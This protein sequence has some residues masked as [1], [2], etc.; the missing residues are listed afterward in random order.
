MAIVRWC[1]ICGVTGIAHFALEHR[2]AASSRQA[3][4]RA[5]LWHRAI[6]YR[7][8]VCF[9]SC[10]GIETQLSHDKR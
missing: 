3:V 5:H 4:C 1:N 2:V 9:W 7:L 10:N 6:Q 8:S